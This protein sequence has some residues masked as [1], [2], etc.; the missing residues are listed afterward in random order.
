MRNSIIFRGVHIA[1]GAVVRNCIIMQ[2]AIVG[3]N[4]NLNY[5]I[6]DKNVV[7]RSG[8][9][10]CGYSSIPFYLQKGMNV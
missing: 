3:E 10:L 1:K 6:A 2:D 7:V 5:V 9:T 4:A 8:R